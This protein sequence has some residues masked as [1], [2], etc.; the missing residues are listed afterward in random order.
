MKRAKTVAVVAVTLVTII[1][2]V[3]FAAPASGRI[4]TADYKL[5]SLQVKKME[6]APQKVKLRTAEAPTIVSLKRNKLPVLKLEADP[7]RVEL[8]VA[9][10]V[11]MVTPLKARPIPLKEKSPSSSPPEVQPPQPNPGPEVEAE[12]LKVVYFAGRAVGPCNAVDART[13]CCTHRVRIRAYIFGN[14]A[15]G[16]MYFDSERY[17][18]IADLTND[19]HWQGRLYK[20]GAAVGK[21]EGRY[22]PEKK[23]FTGTLVLGECEYRLFLW[24]LFI[25]KAEPVELVE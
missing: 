4:L 24:R 10:K 7:Q 17:G 11:R 1:S 2:I 5:V 15:R 19:G 13:A 6:L 23:T 12:K 16:V 9:D 20:E 25:A 22:D 21:F 14:H 18:L 8:K 3:A